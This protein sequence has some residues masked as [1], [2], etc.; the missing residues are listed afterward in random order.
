MK[1]AWYLQLKDIAFIPNIL[2][3][4]NF[5]KRLHSLAVVFLSI[6][7]QV[8]TWGSSLLPH[9][10]FRFFSDESSCC[11]VDIYCHKKQPRSCVQEQPASSHRWQLPLTTFL[12]ER[13]EPSNPQVLTPFGCKL[14]RLS[15]KLHKPI[16]GS[17]LNEPSVWEFRFRT[18]SKKT[19]DLHAKFIEGWKWHHFWPDNPAY[20]EKQKEGKLVP[21]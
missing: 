7:S 9:L 8:Y 10:H 3:L 11:T 17:Q 5:F 4:F 13:G 18:R 19:S 12:V 21:C 16:A 20:M 1:I 14:Y 15:I 2:I 6:L